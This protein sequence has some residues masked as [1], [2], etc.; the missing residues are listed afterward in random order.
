MFATGPL[1]AV[2]HGMWGW[3]M[4]AG[5]AWLAVAWTVLR[6]EPADI[7]HV[8]GPV[9]LFGALTEALR[10]FAGARTWWMNA[11]MSLLFT[12][13]GV[14]LLTAQTSSYTT[15]AALIGW[16]LM[17]R[18]A[19][20]VAVAMMTRETDKVWGLIMVVGVLEAGLGFFAA[21]P[22]S[23][24][25]DL[26]VTIVG[27]LGLLRGVADL[28]TGLRLREV[29]AARADVL[30]LPPERAAG[31]AGYS[32]GMADFDVTPG[33]TAPRHRAVPRTTVSGGTDPMWPGGPTE[34]A[35]GAAGGAPA[36]VAE[37]GIAAAGGMAAAGYVAT[38]GSAAEQAGPI[39]APGTPEA[40]SIYATGHPPHEAGEERAS[41]G[42]GLGGADAGPADGSDS[43][44]GSGDDFHQEVLRTTADLDAML[45][46]A[47][48]TG[49]AVGH[50]RDDDDI[51]EVPD[52]PEGVDSPAE[53]SSK[54][55]PAG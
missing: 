12:A 5:V 25:A 51:P 28:V 11:A 18:G 30:D 2:R 44:A 27:G 20:D 38:G 26:V 35:L 3:L 34:H 23:R 1:A 37:P 19:V 10:A 55:N 33:P 17:V 16:Y 50:R 45:A 6:L 4:L 8:A 29:R 39:I 52:T 42:S 49:A 7:V 24:T 9:I 15:P 53:S 21:S 40:A 13:T 54:S 43:R 48:V 47:G 36:E 31:L 41:T 46:L 32:A 14:I 22:L